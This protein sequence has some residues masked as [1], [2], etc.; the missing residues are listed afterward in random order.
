MWIIFIVVIFLIIALLVKV[1]LG[2]TN[3]SINDASDVDRKTSEKINNPV[4]RERSFPWFYVKECKFYADPNALFSHDQKD[5]D[6]LLEKYEEYEKTADYDEIIKSCDEIILINYKIRKVWI[7]KINAL[8]NNVIK[9]NKEWDESTAKL[10]VNACYGFMKTF[11]NVLERS[12]GVKHILLPILLKNVDN[13]TEYQRN[14]LNEVYNFE[15]YN[16]L[17]NIFYI[18]PF[19]KILDNVYRHLTESKFLKNFEQTEYAKRSI[20]SL[21]GHIEMLKSKYKVELAEY[22]LDNIYKLK[23][24]DTV[25][26]NDEIFNTTWIGFSILFPRDIK[27][28]ELACKFY[29]ERFQEIF[30]E[31]TMLKGYSDLFECTHENGGVEEFDIVILGEDLIKAIDLSIYRENEEINNQVQD[32]EEN[33]QLNLNN[34]DELKSQDKKVELEEKQINSDIDNTNKLS[35]TE[36]NEVI[37]NLTEKEEN[38]EIIPNGEKKEEFEVLSLPDFSDIKEVAISELHVVLL[39]NDGTVKAYGENDK[40]INVDKW[41]DIQKIYATNSATYGIKRDGTI[42][43]A[44]K[45]LYD[46][47]AFDGLWNS[48][49][50]LAPAYNHI[51]GLKKD[52]TVLAIGDNQNGEC[53]VSSWKNIKSISAN[54]HSVGL[55]NDGL[56]VATGEN[57]FGECNVDAW[58]DIVQIETGPFYTVALKGDGTVVATG[59]NSCGQCNVKDWKNISKIYVR[60]NIT[61]GIGFDGKVVITGSNSYRFEEIKKWQNVKDIKIVNDRIIGIMEDGTVTYKGKPYRGIL[62]KKWSRINDL[63]ANSTCV[64]GLRDDGSIICNN[65]LFGLYIP[66]IEN[67]P[68]DIKLDNK[69][70]K[71][72]VLNKDKTI[73]IFNKNNE[74]L[75][76]W[77][78]SRFNDISSISLSDTHLVGIK[79]DGTAVLTG[80]DVKMAFDV[81]AWKNLIKVELG[82]GFA[83]GLK[84]D[85]KVMAAGDNY[86]GQ[87]DVAGWKDVVD[88]KVSGFRTIGLKADGSV[89]F[90][91]F[92]EYEEQEFVKLFDNILEIAV[93]KKQI[94]LLDDIGN[95]KV[96]RHPEGI[97]KTDLANWTQIKHISTV[98]EEF[99]GL[100]EDGT[101]VTTIKDENGL[102]KWN[103]IKLLETNDMYILGKKISFVNN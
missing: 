52:G 9:K 47:T 35:E 40:L 97:L 103:G 94:M 1:L 2:A 23:I 49:V 8:F 80:T 56:V 33:A 99:V 42:V 48:I 21:T 4:I 14:S 79:S 84:I 5:L 25:I 55:T 65:I 17:I 78:C 26:V 37:S 90:T 91:G 87:C 70:G 66:G 50:E 38:Q 100:K 58:T 85:G 43:V 77:D 75:Y 98:G 63:V 83:I 39:K 81:E 101:V 36:E 54:F 6:F 27:R 68:L 22:N 72:V 15:V 60:G 102:V 82:N 59:L 7:D 11:D 67:M 44:D 13:I 12:I 93:N 57:N 88:I 41:T 61:V 20:K 76:N 16:M 64:V 31:E 34:A 62:E 69:I 86:F 3:T 73:E 92:T 19:K 96:S 10:I 51:L 45:N 30:L 95:V 74:V 28:V 29:D 71:M 89:L 32:F 53:N 18:M 24:N 46:S